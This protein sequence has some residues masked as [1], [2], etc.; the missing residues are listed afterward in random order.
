MRRSYIAKEFLNLPT[1]GTFNMMEEA[2]Y[3]GSKMLE[4]EDSI[5]IDVQNLVYYQKLNGEQLDFS[6]ETSLT[7][8]VYSASDNKNTNHTLTL[9]QTQSSFQK[10]NM[11]TWNIQVNLRTILNDYLFAT[12]K[13]YRTFEGL[14][15]EMTYTNDV[16]SSINEY[17]KE[18]VINRYKFSRLDLY[19][20]YKDLRSQNILRY[21]N[22]W[23][24]KVFINENKYTKFGTMMAYDES[25]VKITFNQEKSS[26]LF[27][28]DYYFNILFE[29]I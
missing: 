19:I 16:N 3:F 6:V 26:K 7:S 13:R 25:S 17:I 12:L 14:K 28:F 11:T 15:T 21:K 29:K 9:D 2:N 20:Q 27:N 8:N 22:D 18:N 5:Y 10:D 24:S 4:I 23:K 1:Y